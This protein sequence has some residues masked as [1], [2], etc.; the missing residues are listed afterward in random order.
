[1]PLCYIQLVFKVLYLEG[2]ENEAGMPAAVQPAQLISCP[3]HHLGPRLGRAVRHHLAAAQRVQRMRVVRH[4]LH[5]ITVYITVLAP[6]II[7]IDRPTKN[8]FLK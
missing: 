1:M 3:R 5:N 7:Y 2:G 6:Y 4:F 8:S